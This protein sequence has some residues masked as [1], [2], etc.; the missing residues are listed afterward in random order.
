MDSEVL[1]VGAGPTELTLAIDLGKRG[2][3]DTKP[4]ER[5]K[6][7]S[8]LPLRV[9]SFAGKPD[10]SCMARIVDKFRCPGNI[11]PARSRDFQRRRLLPVPA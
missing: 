3:R 9:A 5:G 4:Q 8:V 2:V 10:G 11:L 6:T 1:I 7:S